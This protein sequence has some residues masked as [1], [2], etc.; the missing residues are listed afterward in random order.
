MVIVDGRI[1]NN[2][3]C[4][5]RIEIR[6]YKWEMQSFLERKHVNFTGNGEVIMYDANH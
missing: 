6:L 4:I 5:L 1:H 2:Q 3:Q